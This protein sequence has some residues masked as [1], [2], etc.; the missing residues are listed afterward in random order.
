MLI[1]ILTLITLGHPAA[2]F[3]EAARAAAEKAADSEMIIDSVKELSDSVADENE[4]TKHLSQLN[5]TSS[6]L[7]NSLMDIGYT[8]DE[9]EEIMKGESNVGDIA[10]SISRT[11]R[12][13]S[14]GKNLIKKIGILTAGS[15][16]AVTATQTMEMNGSLQE[17]LVELQHQ[18]I[19]RE[20]QKDEKRIAEMKVRLAEKRKQAFYKKQFAMMQRSSSKEATSFFPFKVEDQ[21]KNSSLF[22]SWDN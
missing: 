19:D 21:Q 8:S 13:I 3:W 20:Q 7:R 17:I 10:T 4:L 6:D 2:A 16:A 11:A 15:P 9:V 22:G 14:R 12:R 1:N 5:K 18:R